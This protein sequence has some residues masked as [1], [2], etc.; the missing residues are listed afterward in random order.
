MLAP[1]LTCGS[2][3][4]RRTEIYVPLPYGNVEATLRA[5][6]LPH[7]PDEALEQIARVARAGRSL[8]VILHREHRLALELDAC[9]RSVKQRD[10][11]FFRV[12]RQR[13]AVHREAV[14]HRRDLDLAGRQILN[15]M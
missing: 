13:V 14:V 11:R 9:V 10:M 5:L 7:Q 3:I 12:L 2:C 8:G 15:R 1:R 6:A 4:S